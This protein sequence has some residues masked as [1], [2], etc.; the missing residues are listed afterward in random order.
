M[1]AV[2]Q[3]GVFA[4]LFYAIPTLIP[5]W[6]WFAFFAV[7]VGLPLAFIWG[8]HF[9]EAAQPGYKEGPFGFIGIGLFAIITSGLSAGTIARAITL[10]LDHKRSSL[11]RNFWIH[12]IGGI[13][14]VGAPTVWS[15]WEDWKRRPPT[16]AC[17]KTTFDVR[18]GALKLNVP[19][20]PFFSLYTR[21]HSLTDAYHLSI[22]QSLRDL[23]I[24]TGEGNRPLT[25][26]HIRIDFRPRFI[27]WKRFC[28]REL[29]DWARSLCAIK[30]PE[31]DRDLFFLDSA[32]IFCS[33]RLRVAISGHWHQPQLTLRKA[34]A[35]AKNI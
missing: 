15:G 30:R 13:L 18:L 9:H 11:R 34:R 3:F 1:S 16:E 25:V 17:L 8:W 23:C 10:A 26:S 22:P 24:A 6:R 33:T 4:L 32:D 7:V 14:L 5:S 20:S 31:A 2:F 28:D 27:E 21:P 35:Q 29:L 19:A 12:T